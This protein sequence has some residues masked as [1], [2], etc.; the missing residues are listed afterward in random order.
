LLFEQLKAE[1]AVVLEDYA[2]LPFIVAV[3]SGTVSAERYQQF[4]NDLYHVV[5]HFCPTMAAG[6][7]RCTDEYSAVRYA[8]YEHIEDEKGHELWVL[9][10]CRDIGGEAFAGQVSKGLP[11]P[12]IQAMNAFNYHAAERQHGATAFAMVFALEMISQRL[13]GQVSK[14]IAKALKL[15]EGK[16]TKF[17]SS[18]GPLDEGHLVEI[19]AAIDS[20]SDPTIAKLMSNAVMVNYRLFAAM[21]S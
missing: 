7:S 1:S 5:W 13:G 8:L 6:A 2:T 4:L 9:D 14:G 19:S 17:L 20:I 15:E 21:L 11:R 3:R 12:E 10:D 18:H 16:G